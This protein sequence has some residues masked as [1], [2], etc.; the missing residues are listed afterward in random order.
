MWETFGT[1]PPTKPSDGLHFI[2]EVRD[3]TDLQSTWGCI[4]RSWELPN[5][6]FLRREDA[7]RAARALAFQMEITSIG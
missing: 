4:E 7:E 1:D 2:V 5:P 3:L 6:L